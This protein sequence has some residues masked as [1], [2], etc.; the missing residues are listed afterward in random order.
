[1][2]SGDVTATS[3]ADRT[4]LGSPRCYTR[5]SHDAVSYHRFAGYQAI[6]ILPVIFT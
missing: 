2:T 1:M 3:F 4:G 6:R 5:A